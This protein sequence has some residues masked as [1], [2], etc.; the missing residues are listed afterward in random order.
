MKFKRRPQSKFVVFQVLLGLAIFT[1]VCVPHVQHFFRAVGI[2]IIADALWKYKKTR[3]AQTY[4]SL[5]NR[6]SLWMLKK[7]VWGLDVKQWYHTENG[8]WKKQRL[9]Y[10]SRWGEK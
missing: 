3:Q 5:I 9:W 7:S 8:G 10:I 1:L 4:L 2:F 6:I